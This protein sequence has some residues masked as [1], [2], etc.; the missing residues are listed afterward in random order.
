MSTRFFPSLIDAKFVDSKVKPM[1][2][3]LE[4]FLRDEGLFG[5]RIEGEDL[6]RYKYHIAIEGNCAA[7]RVVWQPFLGSV[8][9]IPDGPWVHVPP[10]KIM[11]PWVH[12]VPVMLFGCDEIPDLYLFDCK[13][14]CFAVCFCILDLR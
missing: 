10:V 1:S 8:L 13:K 7:D 9:L 14:L 5:E 4:E 12:Y 6:A 2:Q 11:Q 3:D